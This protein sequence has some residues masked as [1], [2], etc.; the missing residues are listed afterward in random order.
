M[1]GFGSEQRAY[2]METPN[3]ENEED[4]TSVRVT[5]GTKGLLLRTMQLKKDGRRLWRSADDL[6]YALLNEST[7]IQERKQ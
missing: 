6:I 5:K 1:V 2:D 4:I 7:I 3:E